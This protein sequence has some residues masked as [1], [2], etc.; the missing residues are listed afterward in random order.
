MDKQL[1]DY[2]EKE[3][4]LCNHTKYQKYFNVWIKNITDSQIFHFRKDMNKCLN[5]GGFA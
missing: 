4:R 5:N 1:Y 3:W 2:I